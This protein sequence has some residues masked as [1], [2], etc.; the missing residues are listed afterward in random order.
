MPTY[1][2]EHSSSSSV[3]IHG[4]TSQRY[5]SNQPLPH[6][7]LSL[8]KIKSH[9]TRTPIIQF[10]AVHSLKQW[11]EIPHRMLWLLLDLGIK[12]PP[13]LPQ[14]CPPMLPSFS[15]SQLAADP[16]INNSHCSGIERSCMPST[17]QNKL[18]LSSKSSPR[19]SE[20]TFQPDMHLNVKI[21]TLNLLHT[22]RVLGKRLQII[23]SKVKLRQ[24]RETN[25]VPPMISLYIFETHSPY[26]YEG[27][28]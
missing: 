1:H 10:S 12:L 23:S 14:F 17:P 6:D 27:K 16:T 22:F 24:L 26:Q 28:Y 4:W 15:C 7:S 8:W 9:N 21:I 20:V 25:T 11:A 18:Y 13:A 5:L 2:E 19:D 3:L